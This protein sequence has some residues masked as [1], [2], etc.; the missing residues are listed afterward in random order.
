LGCL[1]FFSEL[2]L[3]QGLGEED[4]I[5]KLSLSILCVCGGGGVFSFFTSFYFIV[6]TFTY[7][8]IHCLCPSIANFYNLN[9]S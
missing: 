7:M 9:V 3:E 2:N 1:K 8:C 5:N 4:H 6:F